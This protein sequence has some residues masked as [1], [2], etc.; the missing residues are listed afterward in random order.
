MEMAG[1]GW[2]FLEV[3]GHGW[4]RLEWLEAAGMAGND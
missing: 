1:N 3:A 4:K 2:T